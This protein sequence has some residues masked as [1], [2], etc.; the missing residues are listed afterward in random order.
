MTLSY[1][2]ATIHLDGQSINITIDPKHQT[3]A[4][5]IYMAQF[6]ELHITQFT[7]T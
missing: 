7:H 5:L 1:L 3:L 2:T 4:G 6:N